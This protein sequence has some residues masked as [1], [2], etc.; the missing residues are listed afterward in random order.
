MVNAL[1]WVDHRGGGDSGQFSTQYGADN[2]L[3]ELCALIK[4]LEAAPRGGRVL[5][6]T[7]AQSPV[8]ALR[9]FTRKHDRPPTF[10]ASTLTSHLIATTAPPAQ[11]GSLLGVSE[12]VLDAAGVYASAAGRGCDEGAH[13]RSC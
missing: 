2:Y 13:C 9:S 11:R 5:V 3:G 12:S 6:V 4:A 1:A 10:S 8:A 7:D